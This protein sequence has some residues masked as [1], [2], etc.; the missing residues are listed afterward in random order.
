MATTINKQTAIK[1]H[2]D[3]VG[4]IEVRQ[5]GDTNT[6]HGYALKFDVQY[7]MGWFTESISRSALKSADMTDVRILFN[8]DPS[9]IL[10]RTTSG[11]ATVGVDDT[12]LWYSVDLPKS[13]N[14][15]NVR[16]ALERGDITQSSWGFYL[17]FSGNPADHWEERN[18]KQH[19]TILSVSR[20]VDASP[21]TYPANPDT[22]AAKRSFEEQTKPTGPTPEEIQ[23]ICIKR[24]RIIEL[25]EA[26]N[27]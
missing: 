26:S 24:L 25:M 8:H 7:D 18:G 11:T 4:G 13:P 27:Q 6:L 20:V 16:V 23:N 22:S 5:S 17:D 21:V 12:G 14:G 9:L 10:G 15:E 1:E 2:R 3:C 19:R